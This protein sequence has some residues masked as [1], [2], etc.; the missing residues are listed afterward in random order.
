VV[1]LR[2][3]LILQLGDA[4]SEQIKDLDSNPAGS[5]QRIGQG[6]SGIEGIGIIGP[7]AVIGRRGGMCRGQ[8]G[9]ARRS[10]VDPAGV[11]HAGQ[12]ACS[13]VEQR[14]SEGL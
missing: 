10:G 4:L 3:P 5:G 14:H 12:T 11:D 7:Q 13:A 1:S 2:L 8:G 6:R 9:R